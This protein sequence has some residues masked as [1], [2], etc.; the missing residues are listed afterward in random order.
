[1]TCP[2]SH[3]RSGQAGVLV[4]AE[5]SYP[6]SL[7]SSVPIAFREVLHCLVDPHKV[8]PLKAGARLNLFLRPRLLAN[9]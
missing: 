5:P 4:A 6:P 1:M 7:S 2:L 9:A 3:S 8:D